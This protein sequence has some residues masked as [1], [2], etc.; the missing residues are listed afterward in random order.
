MST[1]QEN[2]ISDIVDTSK[3][4]TTNI[5]Q[6]WEGL[7]ADTGEVNSYVDHNGY[8]ALDIRDQGETMA[9]DEGNESSDAYCS[10]DDEDLSYVDF[11]TEVDDNIVIKTMTI[12][13]PFLNKLCFN[14]GKKKSFKV[15]K[16]TTRSREKTGECISK[17]LQTPMKA[18]NSGG[19]KEHYGRL[20]EYSHAILD[21]NLGSTCRLDDKETSS[22]LL[23][24]VNELLLN[25]EHRKCTRHVFAKFKK[26]FSGVQ[27][28]RLFWNVASTTVEQLV[29]SKMEELRIISQESYQ[30][31]IE[32]NPNTWM[33]QLLE[34][35][36]VHL[37]AAYSHLNRD[38][39]E[40]FD[41]WYSQEKWF[42]AY[43][44][45][46]KPVLGSHNKASCQ[47]EPVPKPLKVNRALV[48]KPTD[49]GTYASAR[50]GGNDG[51]GKR[52][53][54]G[55]RAQRGRGRGQRGR[56]RGQRGR[57]RGQRGRGNGQMLIDEAMTEDEI[58]NHM[59]QEYM[60]EIMLEEEQKERLVKKVKKISVSPSADKG[61]QVAELNEEANPEPQ[62]KKKGSKRK[63]PTSSE[64]LLLRIIYH[65]NKGRSERIFNQKMKKTRFGPDREGSTPNKAFS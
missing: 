9:V 18:I 49:Y 19:L 60:E 21:S 14:S 48:P 15:N 35:L 41:H 50:G 8:D 33:W 27:L 47:K 51:M 1:V 54:A 20:W 56:G 2:E 61:K 64:D 36:C 31:L 59:E 12:N 10:S 16:V 42:E 30:Y 46:I 62:A 52:G 32:R 23:D 45:S 63:A 39:V 28:Q 4:N 53:G 6:K 3:L 57:E 29:Y 65:K 11:H 58:R 17:S 22:G 7:P 44:F 55:R 34:I 26:K 13:Y 5:V 25:A 43:Q 40:G 38:P 24:A 37:V